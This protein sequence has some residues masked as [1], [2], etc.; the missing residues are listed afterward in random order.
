MA[1]NVSYNLLQFVFY[2]DLAHEMNVPWMEY[3]DFLQTY[4]DLTSDDGLELL[5][6]Y[7]Q[8]QSVALCL[9][10]G[11]EI[12]TNSFHASDQQ[13]RFGDDKNPWKMMESIQEMTESD[14]IVMSA[15][16]GSNHL[17]EDSIPPEFRKLDK[18]LANGSA[19]RNDIMQSSFDGREFDL[20][21]AYPYCYDQHYYDR[22]LDSSWTQEDLS[23]ALSPISCLTALF[24]KL[25]ILDRSQRMRMRP[26]GCLSC[27]G[28]PRG[29]TKHLKDRDFQDRKTE[30]VALSSSPVMHNSKSENDAVQSG[31][32]KC[33]EGKENEMNHS[34]SCPSTVETVTGTDENALQS[35]KKDENVESIDKQFNEKCS[36]N[37]SDSFKTCADE[38]NSDMS[39]HNF[40]DANSDTEIIFEMDKSKMSEDELQELFEVL[41]E[42]K[43]VEHKIMEKEKPSKV[44]RD[45]VLD[46]INTEVSKN[47]QIV[48]DLAV[49]P[50]NSSV[51]DMKLFPRIPFRILSGNNLTFEEL[52]IPNSPSVIKVKFNVGSEN[53]F[54]NPI[55]ALAIHNYVKGKSFFVSG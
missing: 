49:I 30:Y 38:S 21:K 15:G 23:S 17:D 46:L 47:N 45:I 55:P 34:I 52:D 6:E 40:E 3:W 37:S 4:V 44:G 14:D 27:M 48:A 10:E 35:E 8:K 41:S 20:T 24:S 43:S 39:S 16:C 54:S 36:L 29:G 9:A 7:L 31:S 42:R 25:S 11:M 51:A 12:L 33:F 18:M 19:K 5:E 2:R 32:Q 13:R 26:G 1:S 28:G 50:V 22:S 53:E